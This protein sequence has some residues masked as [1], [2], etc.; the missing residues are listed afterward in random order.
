MEKSVKRSFGIAGGFWG[1][2]ALVFL[3]PVA[4]MGMPAADR[5][6]QPTNPLSTTANAKIDT[7]IFIE[8]RNL[9]QDGT[10]S[11]AKRRKAKF[12][13]AEYYYYSKDYTDAKWA[14]EEYVQKEDLDIS[15]L[16]AN[17]YLYQMAMTSGKS[18]KIQVIKKRLFENKFV[19]LFEKFQEIKYSSLMGNDYVVQYFVDRIEVHLNGE[20]LISITP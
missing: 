3:L 16:L 7:N 20:L 9:L 6:L 4:V 19:L 5:P 8:L 2:T 14:L 1:G 13:V 17:V 11:K 18:E 12:T 10:V 15:N